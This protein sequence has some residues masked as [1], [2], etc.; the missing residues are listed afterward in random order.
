[1]GTGEWLKT[2]RMFVKQ[3]TAVPLPRVCVMYG[4][5]GCC[6][7]GFLTWLHLLKYEEASLLSPGQLAMSCFC[8]E[9][10]FNLVRCLFPCSSVASQQCKSKWVVDESLAGL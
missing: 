3:Q 6:L 5:A 8:T 1:M 9:E 4:V 10:A 2:L 7:L